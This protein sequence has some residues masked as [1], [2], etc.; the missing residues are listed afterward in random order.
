[1]ASGKEMPKLDIGK[2]F[3]NMSA[4][5]QHFIKKIEQLN[6][7][8]ATD[9]R[10]LKTNNRLVGGVL[11]GAVLGIYF[12]SMFSVRQEKFLDFDEVPGK[13]AQ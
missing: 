12:Y 6:K 11:A 2:E 1:M 13:K 7:L 5:D 3:P 8:R 9:V 10:K 4:S